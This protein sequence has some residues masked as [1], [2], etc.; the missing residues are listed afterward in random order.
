M[1]EEVIK[2]E[3][4][5][6]EAEDQRRETEHTETLSNTNLE[7]RGRLQE[8]AFEIKEVKHD[9]KE[10]KEQTTHP[11]GRLTR[12]EKYMYMLMGG[13]TITGII[14]VPLFLNLFSK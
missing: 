3:F 12:V 10:I 8:I 2:K 6:H 11:N 13:L 1:E 5:K 14:I 4:T 9:V 7:N